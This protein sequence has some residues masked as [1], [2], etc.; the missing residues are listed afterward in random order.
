MVGPLQITLADVAVIAQSYNDITG[1]AC[2]IGK[3]P[4]KGLLDPKAM[5]S[6]NWMYAAKL[7]GEGA[8]MYD[9]ANALAEAMIELGIANYGGKDSL[10]M[11]A[12]AGGEVVKAT[13][14]LFICA[15]LDIKSRG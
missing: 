13:W 14:N 3:Q 15:Y 12:H 6:G 10:S 9:T 1:G 11:A 5:A 4:I 7:D 8:D 2:A